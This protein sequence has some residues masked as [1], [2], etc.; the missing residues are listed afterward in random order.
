MTPIYDADA[1]IFV[2]ISS[3]AAK[4]KDDEA[5]L[6]ANNTAV[7]TDNLLHCAILAIER[8]EKAEA[9]VEELE[10]SIDRSYLAQGSIRSSKHY[11]R[12]EAHKARE[13]REVFRA[14]VEELED[15]EFNRV[16]QE[17]R[18]LDLQRLLI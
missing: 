2:S 6:D 8:A 15:R 5:L 3:F 17:G 14:R 4:Y 16:E 11:Y 18:D 12:A 1:G 10:Y 9:R 13:E 7:T